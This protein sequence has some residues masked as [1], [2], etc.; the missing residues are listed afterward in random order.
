MTPFLHTS[1]M[2]GTDHGSTRLVVPVAVHPSNSNSIIVFDLAQ[3]PELLL[4][5]GAKT[6]RERLYTA[7]MELP[8][9][10]ERPALKQILVNKCPVVAPTST[11]TGD[12]AKRLR[13]DLVTGR[14]NRQTLL[15]P[16]PAVQKPDI[17]WK[18]LM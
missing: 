1:G 8:E 3:N 15:N 12:A 4:D 11:L 13:I 7:N 6:L 16:N 14:R 10:V 17:E 2:Y 9:G 5:L 18:I